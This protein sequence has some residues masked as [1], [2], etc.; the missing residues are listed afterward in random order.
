MSKPSKPRLN[1]EQRA[2]ALDHLP[3]S[4]IGIIDR[5]LDLFEA[6]QNEGVDGLDDVRRHL[7][8]LLS[9]NLV[10]DTSVMDMLWGDERREG[11]DVDV[12]RVA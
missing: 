7:F 9:T 10:G 8:N 12:E 1:V 11:F 2:L 5:I 3:V 4:T 6:K